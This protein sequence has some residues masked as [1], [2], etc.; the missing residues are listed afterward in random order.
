MR[1]EIYRI[2]DSL[3][4]NMTLNNS[5]QDS[6]LYNMFISIKRILLRYKAKLFIWTLFITL[7]SV[8][9]VISIPSTYTSTSSLILEPRRQSPLISDVAAAPLLDAARAE[10]EIQVLKSERLLS[11]VFNSLNSEIVSEINNT[12]QSTFDEIKSKINLFIGRAKVSTRS[13]EDLRQLQFANFGNRISVRR[14]GQSYVVEISY[15]SSNPGLARRVANS[16]ASAYILQS[17]SSKADAARNGAE[18]IQGRVNALNSQVRAASAAVAAGTI[19]DAPTPDGDA[20]IIGAA[21]QPLSPSAPRTYLLILFGA[22]LGLMTGLMFIALRNLFDRRIYG[23]SDLA[24]TFNV[25]CL[26]SSP[27]VGRRQEN[28]SLSYL[29][30]SNTVK[31]DKNR[32]FREAFKTLKMSIE[33]N[34]IRNNCSF[35][36]S[37]AFISQSEGAGCTFISASFAKY[38]HES[39]NNTLLIDADIYNNGRGLSKHFI[40]PSASLS[41]V[42]LSPSMVSSKIGVDGPGLYFIASRTQVEDKDHSLGLDKLELEK[43]IAALD[44]SITVVIDMPSSCNASDARVLASHVE[45]VVLVVKAGRSTIDEFHNLLDDVSSMKTNIIGYVIN[46]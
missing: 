24:S 42:I 1:E 39:G 16:T 9:Y 8:F 19:P 32:K 13:S 22:I 2:K 5:L 36:R 10:S 14:I 15:I 45:G 34:A 29:E 33:M 21:L 31:N 46:M 25:R 40:E 20:R 11:T 28:K 38:L 3:D 30:K 12:Q 26:G 17:V 41:D 43:F 44:P 6:S 7:T 18:F 35:P 27:K 37:L 23:E 4:K